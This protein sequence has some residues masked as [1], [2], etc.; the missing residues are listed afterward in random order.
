LDQT[1]GDILNL[2]S[3]TSVVN[4]ANM[5]GRV[6][7]FRHYCRVNDLHIVNLDMTVNGIIA[8]SRMNDLNASLDDYYGAMPARVRELTEAAAATEL[9]RLAEPTWGAHHAFKFP[10]FMAMY[11]M[12]RTLLCSPERRFFCLR[13]LTFI[14]VGESLQG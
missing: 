7:N 8:Q 2:G 11:H 6:Q 14:R 5:I 4:L 13:R 1:M 10:V 3:W 9:Y 12:L